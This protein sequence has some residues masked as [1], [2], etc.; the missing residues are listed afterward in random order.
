[1]SSGLCI[2]VKPQQLSAHHYQIIC[3]AIDFSAPFSITVYRQLQRAQQTSYQAVSGFC[4][5]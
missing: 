2:I 1:M 5:D 3:N 4:P